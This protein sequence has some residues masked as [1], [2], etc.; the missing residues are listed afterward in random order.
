MDVEPDGDILAETEN[1]FIWR[2][3]GDDGSFVYHVELGGVSLHL[4]TEE[5]DE[6][7]TLMKSLPDS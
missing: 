6:L 5:W 2:S 3:E 7:I 1:Y 4:L